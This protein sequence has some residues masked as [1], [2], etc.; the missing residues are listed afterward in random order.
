MLFYFFF[1]FL[2]YEDVHF[3]QWLIL[4]YHQFWATQSTKITVVDSADSSG[5]DMFAKLIGQAWPYYVRF[6]CVLTHPVT[7][8]LYVATPL[9]CGL[10]R[11]SI[12]GWVF[13]KILPNI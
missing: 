11:S 4:D 10:L 1:F 7:L 3:C 8:L 13:L 9:W 12:D 2:R 6:D 5:L